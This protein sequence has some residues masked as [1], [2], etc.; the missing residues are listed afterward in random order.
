MVMVT[1][2]VLVMA[3][4]D[5]DGGYGADGADLHVG[6]HTG[7]GRGGHS[8][9]GLG[10]ARRKRHFR[11]PPRLP[12]PVWPGLL[13]Y[14]AT[15]PAPRASRTSRCCPSQQR[16]PGE[17]EMAPVFL[18]AGAQRGPVTFGDV[19]VDFSRE[20]WGHLGSAQKELYREVMLENY[21]NLVGLGLAVSKPR[22]IEQLERGEAPWTPWGGVPSSCGPG[23][24]RLILCVPC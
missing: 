6:C 20:E 2:M 15:G 7:A 18:A 22:V 4:S 1:K 5:D 9:A 13:S 10:R 14:A 19:A 11:P 17:E 21:R 12:G 24:T 8:R 23:K 3:V 16:G